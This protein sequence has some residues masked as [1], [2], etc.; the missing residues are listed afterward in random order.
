MRT[1]LKIIGYIITA[2]LG[3][4]GLAGVPDDLAQW[5]KWIKELKLM[6]SHDY[7]RYLIVFAAVG[8]FFG[9]NYLPNLW[10]KKSA[11]PDVENKDIHPNGL[12]I[13]HNKNQSEYFWESP[14]LSGVFTTQEHID[15]LTNKT[16]DHSAARGC[17][18]KIMNLSPADTAP[19]IRTVLEAIN[20]CPEGLSLT[21][22]LKFTGDDRRTVDLDP[23]ES[24][25]VEII[26]WKHPDNG[27]PN[28]YICGVQ[29]D[30]A[31]DVCDYQIKIVV[32]G[33]N[34]YAEKTLYVEMRDKDDRGKKI[35]MW[36]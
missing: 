36:A 24:K 6:I 30:V 9:I 18:V 29:R 28:F 33:T 15:M 7:V 11:K 12:E 1:F 31:I 8:L 23:R 34:I 10:K 22:E 26:Y 25:F 4:I 19:N 13:Q 2:I 20:P 27:G 32:R 17:R 3:F 35:W 16:K 14:F 21:L 5:A